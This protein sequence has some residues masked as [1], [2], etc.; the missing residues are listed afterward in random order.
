MGR[1]PVT[2]DTAGTGGWYDLTVVAEGTSFLRGF[3]GHLENGRPS[4][5]EPALGRS[6]S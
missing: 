1:R 2:I 3:A 4:T 5:S 6:N